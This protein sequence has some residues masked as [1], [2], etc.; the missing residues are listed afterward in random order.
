MMF[1]FSS[2]MLLRCYP[3]MLCGNCH[4]I[5]SQW[6]ASLYFVL[7]LAHTSSLGGIQW[8][9]GVWVTRYPLPH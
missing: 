5:L 4:A 8:C 2:D 3:D 1:S 6:G 7:T 9:I